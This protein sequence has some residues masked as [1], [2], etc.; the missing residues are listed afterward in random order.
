MGGNVAI[1]VAS[2]NFYQLAWVVAGN[3]FVR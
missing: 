2:T 3:A 1:S